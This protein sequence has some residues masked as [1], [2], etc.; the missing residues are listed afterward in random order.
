MLSDGKMLMS[1]LPESR[2]FEIKIL[3]INKTA[4]SRYILEEKN[5]IKE[6]KFKADVL[7]E[8]T[9]N[10]LD[11]GRPSLEGSSLEVV[12]LSA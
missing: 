2:L 8:F 7:I 6:N 10:Y 9:V 5:L 12:P 11:S 4:L 3:K 1:C